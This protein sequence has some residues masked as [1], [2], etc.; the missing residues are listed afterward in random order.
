MLTF[1]AFGTVSYFGADRHRCRT[2]LLE[3]AAVRRI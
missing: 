2:G 3:L 1:L